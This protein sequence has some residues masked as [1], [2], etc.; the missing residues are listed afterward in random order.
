[1]RD[2]HVTGVQTCALPILFIARTD[3]A[4][5]QPGWNLKQ[6][7]NWA[8][9][10]YSGIDFVNGPVPAGIR[11]EVTQPESMNAQSSAAV[12]DTAGQLRS[13][14]R[15]VGNEWRARSES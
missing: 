5:G 2:F 4:Y 9:I 7:G 8:F 10:E 15:R 3:Y 11:T 6:N 14:E 1:I 12:S 13:E